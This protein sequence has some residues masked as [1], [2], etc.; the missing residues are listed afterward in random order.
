[1]VI[2]ISAPTSGSVVALGDYF[3]LVQ[4]LQI[5]DAQVRAVKQDDIEKRP[6]SREVRG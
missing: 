6:V 1:M 2:D 4:Y 3:D 5:H